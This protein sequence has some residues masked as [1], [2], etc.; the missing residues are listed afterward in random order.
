VNY[1]NDHAYPQYIKDK[2]S[3]CAR[4]VGNA[5]E[6]GGI[7]TAGRPG[8]AKNYGPFLQDKGFSTVSPTN[9]TPIK[10]D[11]RVFQP[12]P[13]GSPHGHINMYNGNQWISDFRENGFWPGPG[14]RT[15]QP[16]FEIFRFGTYP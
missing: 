13:T 5:L 4:A 16:A 9:Y 11:I 14:Y 6:A 2:C 10:G 8:S 15:Y 12:Y 3:Y 1:L 7:N